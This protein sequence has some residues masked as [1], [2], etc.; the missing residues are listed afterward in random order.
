MTY[1]G[2]SRCKRKSEKVERYRPTCHYRVTGGEEAGCVH[3][4]GDTAEHLLYSN[5]RITD[6]RDT[7]RTVRQTH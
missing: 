3:N 1:A 4:L 5:S 2:S 7:L 6:T